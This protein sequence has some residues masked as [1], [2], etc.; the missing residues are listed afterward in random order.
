M[1][2]RAISSVFQTRHKIIRYLAPCKNTAPSLLTQRLFQFLKIQNWNFK[3]KVGIGPVRN[4]NFWVDFRVK[5]MALGI[6]GWKKQNKNFRVIPN[7]RLF[8]SFISGSPDCPKYSIL[9]EELELLLTSWWYEKLIKSFKD[10]I[11]EFP[12]LCNEYRS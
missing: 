2:G 9:F 8:S 3:P 10:F 6:S 4:E 11:F 7:F 12:E 5:I 1:F